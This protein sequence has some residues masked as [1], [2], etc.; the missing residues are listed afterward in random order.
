MSMHS[1]L[2]DD[3]AEAPTTALPA[4]KKPEEKEEQVT[5]SEQVKAVG[6]LVAVAIGVGAVL[7]IALAAIFKDSAN[8]GTIAS[9]AGGVIATMVGAYFGV[10]VGTDQSKTAAENQKAEAAKAQVY[11]LHLNPDR[12]KAD[13]VLKEADKAAERAVKRHRG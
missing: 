10:K 3:A 11:A 12:A 7:I 4:E 1:E 5:F 9:A 2:P 13:E 6:G 8:A